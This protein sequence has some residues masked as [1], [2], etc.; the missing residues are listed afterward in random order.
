MYREDKRQT[1]SDFKLP[2]VKAPL[3]ACAQGSVFHLE[4]LNT[5][6]EPSFQN[7]QMGINSHLTVCAEKVK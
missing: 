1:F 4:F 3:I 2:K 5:V 7:W 6:S